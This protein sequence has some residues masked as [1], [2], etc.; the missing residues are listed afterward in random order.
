MV[1]RDR[2]EQVARLLRRRERH[3]LTY[4]ELSEESGI[5]SRTLAW[6]SWKLRQERESPRGCELVPVEVI[7]DESDEL[8]GTIEIV[9]GGGM[10][11]IVPT[12]ASEALLQRVLRAVKTC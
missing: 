12:T 11:V 10:S 5:P 2:R 8:S 4:R 3:S 9:I 1:E 7:E 6:W